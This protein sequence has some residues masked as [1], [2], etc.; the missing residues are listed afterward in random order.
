VK[1]SLAGDFEEHLVPA[2]DGSCILVGRQTLL[3]VPTLEFVILP[4][5][6]VAELLRKEILALRTDEEIDEQQCRVRML[7]MRQGGDASRID[8][9]QIRASHPT[10]APAQPPV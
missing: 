1:Y 3:R 8:R 6:A 2:L 5:A 7:G 10:G 9:D 4:R